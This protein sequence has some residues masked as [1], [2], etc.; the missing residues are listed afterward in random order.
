M[1]G[2]MQRARAGQERGHVRPCRNARRE[3]IAPR[4]HRQAQHRP[5]ILQPLAQKRLMFRVARIRHGEQNQVFRANGR[6]EHAPRGFGARAILRE[7]VGTHMQSYHIFHIA[8]QRAFVRERFQKRARDGCAL[9]FVPVS[10]DAPVPHRG[11]GGLAHIMAKRGKHEI[12]RK[13]GAIAQRGGAAEHLQGVREDVS[14]WMKARSC[15]VR[16]RASSGP[17]NRPNARNQKK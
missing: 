3:Q 2:K 10:D 17:G 9:F 14:L 8:Q 1:P 13:D 12:E 4:N 11:D 6:I 15:G 16:S 7:P 5:I